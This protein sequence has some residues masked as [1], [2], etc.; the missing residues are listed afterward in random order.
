MKTHPNKNRQK[1]TAVEILTSSIESGKRKVA[2]FMEK[3]S[4]RLSPSGK[5]RALICFGL[6]VTLASIM[7]MTEPFRDKA[8]NT[9]TFFPSQMEVPPGTR[10]FPDDVFSEEDYLLLSGFKRT[11]DSLKQ[12]DPQVYR[13]LLN[14][15]QGLLDSM[16]YLLRMYH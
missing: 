1:Q 6:I 14:G 5:K 9:S 8:V 10:P 2:D 13:E 12:Y 16:D 11:L 15:R 3:Q 7:M 4:E